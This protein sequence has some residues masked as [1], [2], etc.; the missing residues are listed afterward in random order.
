MKRIAFTAFMLFTIYSSG[1]GESPGS[2]KQFIEKKTKG[3]YYKIDNERL[4]SGNTLQK[5]YA[6][7]N[8][9]HAWFNHNTF[10]KNGYALIDYIRQVDCQGLRPEDYHLHL[11]EEYIGKLL[12][13]FKPMDTVDM[14]KLDILLTD[15]F[16]LLGSNLYYGKVYPEKEGAN[17]KMLR[18]DPELRLDLKLEEA[19]NSND[20]GKELDMLAP[21]YRAYWKMKEELAFYLG[22]NGQSWPA[23]ISDIAIKPGESNQLIPLIRKRLVK[24]RYQ[25]SDT[26]S[27]LFDEVLG[28]QLRKFQHDW[29]L[30]DDGL[31]GKS[32]LEALNSPPS[33]LI[34]QLKVNME[35]YRWLSLPLAEKYIIINIANFKLDLIQGP[36]TLLSMRAIVGKEA[37]Q[38]PVFNGQISYI[39]FSPSWT[40]PP[41]ILKEDVIPQLLKGPDYLEKN[42]MKLLSNN[43]SE[44]AYNDIDW[45]KVSVDNFPYMVRQGPGPS[46]ALGR[47][48]FIFPNI[49]D[50]YIHDTP[51]K[52]YFAR[53]DRAMS[54]GCIRIEK[55]YDLAV[56]LL[57][58]KPDWVPAHIRD[59]MEQDKEET[60]RLKIPVDV[61]LIYL[62]AWT[63]GK[64]HVQFRRDVYQRDE[65]ILGALNQK[66][67][68]IRDTVKP[69]K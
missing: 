8:Y 45:S 59:A 7:R 28:R 46:N 15:S 43:G 34:S 11:I 25:L 17:W 21:R 42:N 49:E 3:P 55:P 32:T 13:Y 65:L 5:F 26:T 56:F 48:K 10:S 27:V 62:T 41:T 57:S 18:K 14:M 38:T 58:D 23:I 40:V 64:D 12:Y 20:V 67:E 16:M 30:N 63:D 51:S 1:A 61:L 60:V 33:K 44:L 35:R 19:L 69:L 39:V 53:D 68:L 24:L 54:S 29:G 6:D 50:V 36:D 9:T 22:L 47:V 52:G 4:L 66:P 31:I 2:I 37:R